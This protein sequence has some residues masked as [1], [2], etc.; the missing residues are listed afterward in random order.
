M[1]R[2][3]DSTKSRAY[4]LGKKRDDVC[5]EDFSCEVLLVLVA[6]SSFVSS[7]SLCKFL[8]WNVCRVCVWSGSRWESVH[9]PIGGNEQEREELARKWGDGLRAGQNLNHHHHHQYHL[10]MKIILLNH[11]VG[12]PL[13]LVY[14][15]G[16][17]YNAWDTPWR[18]NVRAGY[19]SPPSL[20]QDGKLH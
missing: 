6:T 17:A 3:T 14:V 11:C 19:V 18:S 9:V 1:S 8:G 7:A 12:S 16:S 15:W 2:I 4:T 20:C 13:H 5:M 10:C